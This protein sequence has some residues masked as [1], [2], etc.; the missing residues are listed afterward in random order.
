MLQVPAQ[1]GAAAAGAA[2]ELKG[3]AGTKG[4]IEDGISEDIDEEAVDGDGKVSKAF[5]LME[6]T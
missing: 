3:V 1:Q 6:F 5:Q 4:D 2:P